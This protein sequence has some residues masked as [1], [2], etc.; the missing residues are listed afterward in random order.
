MELYNEI[1]K[2]IIYL[3][4][5]LPENYLQQLKNQKY[6]QLYIYHFGIGTW[7][8]NNVLTP[9][10]KITSLLIQS[11]R[12]ELDD[13]SMFIIQCLYIHLNLISN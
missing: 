1:Q 9:E 4:S 13:M 11:G 5:V 3:K 12:T 8:R 2:C 10:A 7:L 6:S